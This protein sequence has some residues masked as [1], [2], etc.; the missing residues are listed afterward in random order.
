M[1]TV[2]LCLLAASPLL[3]Q[4]SQSG[5]N[6]DKSN[7]KQ[8]PTQGRPPE[9]LVPPP[10]TCQPCQ[11]PAQVSATQSNQNA[12][13]PWREYFGEAFGANNLPSWFLGLTAVVAAAVALR[14]LSAIQ[15]QSR[16]S[17]I[18]LIAT[19]QAV[20]AAKASVDAAK[21]SNTLTQDSNTITREAT[22]LTRQSILLTHRPRLIVRTFFTEP[23]KTFGGAS[24][25][26]AS[27]A[28]GSHVDGQFYIVNIGNSAATV[29]EI[30][31]DVGVWG[32]IPMKRPYEGLSGESVS[33]T[34]NPGQSVPWKFRKEDPLTQVNFSSLQEGARP[35]P[36]G[37]GQWV[38]VFGFVAYT[39][40]LG[41]SRKTAFC[42]KYNMRTNR[43]EQS[44]HADYEHAE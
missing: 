36:R 32:Y 8:N 16:I 15:E 41:T 40:G 11:L 14:T 18:G 17:R 34:L 39:D 25:L 37:G 29:T 42:R 27:F 24:P 4:P 31:A 19:R 26:P 7:Q 30:Y 35:D 13:Q 5:K 12:K 43:F 38:F 3:G 22:Q 2:Y 23:P 1:R 44:E 21:E 9:P 6:V 28:E 33:F 20:H 10:I